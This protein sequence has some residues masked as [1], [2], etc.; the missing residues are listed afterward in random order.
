MWRCNFFRI[1]ISSSF[2]SLSRACLYSQ[3]CEPTYAIRTGCHRLQLLDL[4]DTPHPHSRLAKV[5]ALSSRHCCLSSL[6]LA[7][8]LALFPADN[9][10]V[11]AW[12][13]P[14][15]PLGPSKRADLGPSFKLSLPHQVGASF[16]SL[17]HSI[18][19]LALVRYACVQ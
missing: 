6:T 11:G 17:N 19:G 1:P 10:Y 3:L 12:E 7:P 8:G 16:L 15:L 9:H 4:T 18:Y 2:D 14:V 13:T 5:L